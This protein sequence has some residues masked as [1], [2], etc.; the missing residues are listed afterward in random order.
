MWVP[1]SWTICSYLITV[2]CVSTLNHCILKNWGGGVFSA[3]LWEQ[4]R[5]YEK[6][7]ELY[8]LCDN[9]Q[10]FSMFLSPRPPL[11]KTVFKDSHIS[12]HICTSLVHLLFIYLF[13]YLH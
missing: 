1:V 10:W 3:V 7:Y 8:E 11:V 5:D 12:R 13:S 2:L 6:M 9:D 4:L